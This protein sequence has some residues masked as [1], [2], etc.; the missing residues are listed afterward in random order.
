LS[1]PPPPPSVTPFETEQ[2]TVQLI[3]TNDALFLGVC[4]IQACQMGTQN[5]YLYIGEWV[6]QVKFYPMR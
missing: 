5:K 1:L 6:M 3:A 4:R 2:E